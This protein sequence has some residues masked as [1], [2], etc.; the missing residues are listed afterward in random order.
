MNELFID[1][2]DIP[3]MTEAKIK[4]LLKTFKTPAGIF[5]ASKNDLLDV[6]GIDEEIANL[7]KNY[8]RSKETEEKHK[9]LRML[10]GKVVSFLD[11]NYPSNLKHIAHAP[12]V[13][14]IRG[15]IK[16]EDSKAIAIVGTRKPTS[17]GRMV[18]EKFAYELAKLGI[19]IVSGLARGIDTHAHLGALK[20]SG[21][22]I[23]VLGCGIDVYY[24]PENKKYYEDISNNGAVISEFNLGTA[25]LAINFP[26][27]NR[28]ISGLVLG[29]LAVEAPANSGVLNTVNWA[30]DQG[31]EVFAVPGAID[32]NTSG[33]TNQLIKDGAKPVTCVEDICDELK[34]A[35]DKEIKKDIPLSELEKQIID[36]L[37]GEPLYPDQIAEAIKVQITVL[38]PQLLSLEIKGLIKQLPGNKYTKTF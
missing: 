20:A 4:N 8:R 14:F 10:N 33:G 18:A 19:T 17:Y 13:L 12:P 27:R 28:I 30:L 22:T 2:Y 37:S 21:R 7:I 32:K 31:K 1:L 38:L 5:Q 9:R 6:K 16:E 34:I 26:R 35:Y 25:P 36:V 3:R 11:D 24:P 29:V 23:A 15:T